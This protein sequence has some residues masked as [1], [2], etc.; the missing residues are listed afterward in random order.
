MNFSALLI[1]LLVLAAVLAPL[2]AAESSADETAVLSNDRTIYRDLDVQLDGALFQGEAAPEEAERKDLMLYLGYDESA[3]EN[4]F[5]ERFIGWAGER[6]DHGPEDE[7]SRRF[8]NM[9][10]EGAVTSAK[11]EGDRVTLSVDVLVHDDPWVK[12]GEASYTIDL[13]RRGDEFTG[14]Y[15]GTFR[16]QPVEGKARGKLASKP[17]PAAIADWEPLEVGEHPRL[18]F[19]KSDVP[20]LRRRAQTEEGKVIVA[21]LRQLLGAEGEALPESRS[22]A[23]RAYEKSN[24]PGPNAF[25]LGHGA[26]YGMLYQLTG[27]QKY[28]DLAREATELAMSGVRDRDGR[29]AWNNPG[30]KLRA[31]PSYAQIAYAYDLAYDAW[32]PAFREKVAK[33]LQDKVWNPDAAP[34][35]K[36]MKEPTGG[37]LIF[38]TGGGQHSPHSNHYGAWNGGAGVAILAILGDPGTDDA[39]T[40]RAHR[41]LQQRAERALEVGFG[42]SAWFFE[43]HH[44]GRLNFNTGLA[45]YLISLRNAAGLDLVNNFPGG[46]WLT[47]KWLY[48]LTR[49]NGRIK[50]VNRGIYAD[51]GYSRGDWSGSG[52]FSIGFGLVPDEDKPTVEWFFQHVIDPRPVGESDLDALGLPSRAAW[53]LVTWPVHAEPVNPDK[54]LPRYLLDG[55]A[56]YYVLRSGWSDDGNDWVV[57]VQNGSAM[58]RGPGVKANKETMPILGSVRGVTPLLDGKA[59]DIDTGEHRLIADM[60]GVSGAPIVMIEMPHR[61]RDGDDDTTTAEPANMDAGE[62]EKAGEAKGADEPADAASLFKERFGGSGGAAAAE[63]KAAGTAEGTARVTG[64]G[65]LQQDAEL[66]RTNPRVASRT[67]RVGRETWRVF[68]VQEGAAPKLEVIERDGRAGLAVGDRVVSVGADGGVELTTRGE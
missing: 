48:E 39:V 38:N 43:G 17:W 62:A 11:V 68:T 58:L 53:A 52:D 20:E 36:A 18:M 56:N 6:R 14:T 12:G 40:Y 13:T 42:D 60:S 3:K 21:R 32:E 29:Y 57:A 22:T 34:G 25:T 28:A 5:R 8:N 30:G 33:A 64:A 41:V 27:E 45:E 63:D 24:G 50:D 67:I 16:G 54:L 4:P 2:H 61:A 46:R 49:E 15:R 26:G 44:G 37:D 10:H 1:A 35:D 65:G 47:A 51:H 55:K 31:G 7:K 9:D 23:T 59:G 19:R 66:V